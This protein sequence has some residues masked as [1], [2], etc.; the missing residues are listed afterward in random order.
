MNY[1]SSHPNNMTKKFEDT[2]MNVYFGSQHPI[3]VPPSNLEIAAGGTYYTNGSVLTVFKNQAID[4]V[5]V[6]RRSRPKADLTWTK[7]SIQLTA[8]TS[9]NGSDYALWNTF[10]FIT[11]GPKAEDHWK[12]LECGSVFGPIEIRTRIRLSVSGRYDF[13]FL[14]LQHVL[15]LM[16]YVWFRPI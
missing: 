7:D 16:Y 2:W 12:F 8:S 15:Y 10:S 14:L 1:N 13:P 9:S 11:I 6:S 4:F 5:C 3:L